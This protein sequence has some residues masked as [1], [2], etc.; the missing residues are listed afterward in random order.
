MGVDEKDYKSW[1]ESSLDKV[2]SKTK[3]LLLPRNHKYSSK[4]LC[5]SSGTLNVY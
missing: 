1:K 4:G 3:Y 2:G 5:G